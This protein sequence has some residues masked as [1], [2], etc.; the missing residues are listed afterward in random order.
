MLRLQANSSIPLDY[1]MVMPYYLKQKEP[2][3]DHVETQR[4][5]NILKNLVMRNLQQI[6]I[7]KNKPSLKDTI[8]E[9][10]RKKEEKDTRAR[11]RIK[12]KVLEK[13]EHMSFK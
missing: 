7:E 10:M 5:E 8:A 2:G 9:F 1:I 4:L 3:K 6:R 12:E 11:G 13:Y